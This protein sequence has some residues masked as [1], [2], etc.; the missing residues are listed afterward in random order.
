MAQ[1]LRRCTPNAGG[2]G[3]IPGQGTRSP[4]LQLRLGTGKEKKIRKCLIKQKKKTQIIKEEI[5]NIFIESEYCARHCVK[6]FTCI[7]T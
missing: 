4:M 3:L 2:L 5:S 7:N 6:C 1:W